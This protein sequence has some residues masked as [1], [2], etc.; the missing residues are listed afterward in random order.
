MSKVE[1]VDF[2]PLGAPVLASSTYLNR[3]IRKC[4]ATGEATE[5]RYAGKNSLPKCRDSY[6]LRGHVCALTW[7]VNS[8]KISFKDK[9][10]H[11]PICGSGEL[12]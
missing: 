6:H 8:V 12:L 2:T 11:E 7:S 9:P 5:N 1:W 10:K 4:W 3:K